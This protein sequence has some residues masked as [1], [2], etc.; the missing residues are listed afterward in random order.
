MSSARFTGSP[1]PPV[2]AATG[3]REPE[4]FGCCE[5]D[6]EVE[7]GWLLYWDVARL[8]PAQNLV[9]ILGGAPE[10]V[11]VV[12]SIGHQPSHSDVLAKPVDCRQSR[13]QRQ[14]DDAN[15]VGE[16]ERVTTDIQSLCATFEHLE[17]G[18]HIL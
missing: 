4:G 2:A 16:Y 5:V 11:R 13:A 6:H 12:C 1:D 9:D 10:L 7:P 3:D 18:R 17:S 8:R 14:G 15:A